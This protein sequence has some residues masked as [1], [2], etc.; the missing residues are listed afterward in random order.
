MEPA[1]ALRGRGVL[2]AAG[3]LAMP[4]P[5]RNGREGQ[6]LRRSQRLCGGS[7]RPSALCGGDLR[8][9]DG[10]SQAPVSSRGASGA[11]RRVLRWAPHWGARPSTAAPTHCASQVT[12]AH[13]SRE[14]E[15]REPSF[16]ASI[17]RL[18]A[19]ASK[20]ALRPLHAIGYA[21]L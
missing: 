4:N 18:A 21:D 20:G 12:Q 13:S 11:A 7:A 3:S 2:T 1:A 8:K 16:S 15:R 14:P 5:G 9:A 6:G 17:V 19:T 10:D